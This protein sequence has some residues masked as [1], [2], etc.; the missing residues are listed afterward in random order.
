AQGPSA[1]AARVGDLCVFSVDALGLR[2][3]WF[4]ETE[5]EYFTS[6][7]RGVYPLDMMSAEPKPLAPGEKIALEIEPGRAIRVLDYPAIQRHVLNKYRERGIHFTESSGGIWSLNEAQTNPNGGNGLHQP[8]FTPEY[9]ESTERQV[10]S[11]SVGVALA[12]AP[13]EV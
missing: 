10:K 13:A 7:E 12:D 4:G 2:P 8:S 9:S 6:S 11:A 3:L 5:K 1:V